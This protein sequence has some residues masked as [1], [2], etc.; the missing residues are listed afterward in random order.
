MRHLA[1]ASAALVALTAGTL[2]EPA[3]GG[4]VPIQISTP[5]RSRGR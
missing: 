4:G 2:V 3:T 5:P 1:A